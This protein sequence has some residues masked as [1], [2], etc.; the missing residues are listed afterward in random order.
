M[1]DSN[2][3]LAVSTP[4]GEKLHHPHI[5]TLQHHL[6]EV[7]VGEHHHILLVAAAAALLSKI[8]QHLSAI[9]GYVRYIFK[10]QKS[11]YYKMKRSQRCSAGSHLFVVARAARFSTQPLFYQSPQSVHG[12]VHDG[13]AAAPA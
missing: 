10:F 3:L 12:S 2:S 7:V 6:V 5:V 11:F 13:L 9:F 4:G 1:R 8:G